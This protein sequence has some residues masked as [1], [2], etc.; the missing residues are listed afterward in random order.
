MLR[1]S[2][3]EQQV[4]HYNMHSKTEMSAYESRSTAVSAYI[5]FGG[6]VLWFSGWW[7]GDTMLHSSNKTKYKFSRVIFFPKNCPKSCIC[8]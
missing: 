2:H 4:E 3:I 6:G 1:P 5:E 7:K 8:T